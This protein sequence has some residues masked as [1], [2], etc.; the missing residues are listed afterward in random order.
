MAHTLQY[1]SCI[2]RNSGTWLS[3]ATSLSLLTS[4]CAT[5]GSATMMEPGD[6]PIEE[7]V[8]PTV[9]A[10]VDGIIVDREGLPVAGKLVFIGGTSVTTDAAGRFAFVDV[11]APYD[12]IVTEIGSSMATSIVGLTSA[13]PYL[14]HLHSP[15][16]R[17]EAIRLALNSH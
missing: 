10:K 16:T 12:V 5:D 3:L 15:H 9:L 1:G 14:T 11:K 7:T 4:A 6:D 2:M 8:Q 17:R 13:T